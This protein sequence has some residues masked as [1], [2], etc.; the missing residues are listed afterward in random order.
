MSGI[1]IASPVYTLGDWQANV[2]DEYG[3][4]WICEDEKGWSSSPPVRPIVEE[5]QN[6]DG[7]WSG[8][9]FY[10]SRVI[11][12]SGRA[13]IADQ[14]GMLQAKDRIRGA[15]NARKLVQLRVDEMHLSRVSDV[16]LTD[17]IELADQGAHMFTW[18]MTV[19]APDPRRYLAESVTEETT[20]PATST[21]GRIYDRTYPLVYGGGSGGGIGSVYLDQWGTYDETPAV[22]TIVGPVISPRVE[23]IQTGRSLTFDLTVEY[24]QTL[25]LDLAT[26]TALLNG[27][28]NRA[29]DLSAGSGWFM[30][31][32]GV[33]EL[34]F[35]G[36]AGSLPPEADPATQPVMSVTAAPAWT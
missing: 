27:T 13:H 20:L 24:G 28:A 16:R 15:V 5:R 29:A 1:P 17:T 4:T 7:A 12:L 21:G 33:N 35:R 31:V 34:A 10:G 23:H 6:A 19:T 2:V 36:Q 30:L 22:I 11:N 18:Q 25:V 32:P 9:G 8:P 3:V 14:V 26:K